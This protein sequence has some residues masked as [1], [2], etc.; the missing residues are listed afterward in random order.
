MR[1]RSGASSPELQAASE[2]TAAPGRCIL[3]PLLRSA[4]RTRDSLCCRSGWGHRGVHAPDGA[5]ACLVFFEHPDLVHEGRFLH[6]GDVGDYEDLAERALEALQREEHV[7]AAVRI[8]APED[9][10]EDEEA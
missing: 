7:V 8:Q 9:L 6:L 1:R 3:L 10:V 4:A 2:K 5:L